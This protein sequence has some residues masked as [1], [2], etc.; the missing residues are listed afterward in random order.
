MKYLIDTHILIWLAISPQEISKGVLR[1]LEN[2]ENKVFVSTVSL[3]EIAIKLSIGK[4]DLQ[5]L[6][7]S[8][9]VQFC[10]EQNIEIIQLPVSAVEQ[11]KKLPKKEKHKDPFDR[12]LI[13]LSIADDYTLV[14]SDGK[15]DLYREDGLVYI[16]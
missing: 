14:S 3:W 11:Y 13:S 6:E 7:I 8:D 15:V 9:L 4:L 1:I 5:G 10:S 2:S 16:S 12:F